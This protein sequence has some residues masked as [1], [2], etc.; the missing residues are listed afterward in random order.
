MNATLRAH[1]S[2]CLSPVCLHYIVHINQNGC[3]WSE[4]LVSIRITYSDLT[5]ATLTLLS[6]VFLNTQHEKIQSYKREER[7]NI[8][9]TW[10]NWNSMCKSQLW[11]D[12][13]SYFLQKIKVWHNIVMINALTVPRTCLKWAATYVYSA[14]IVHRIRPQQGFIVI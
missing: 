5:K 6:V 11:T 14:V 12:I 1:L 2:S 8:A 3:R 7:E 9:L 10:K 13:N 4:A